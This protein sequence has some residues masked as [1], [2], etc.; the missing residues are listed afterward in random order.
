[1]IATE[2]LELLPLTGRQMRLWAGDLP[3]LERELGCAYAGE[4][5]EGFFLDIVRAQAE[6]TVL[7]EENWLYHT[8]WMLL[9]RQDRIVVGSADFKKPPNQ[10]GEVEIGYGL[11][12]RFWHNGYMAEAV[13]G[14]SRWALAQ[15]GITA[16]VAETEPDNIPSQNVLKRC[17]FCRCG[18][19][20]S[21]WWR[22]TGQG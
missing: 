13:R 12:E 19:E 14:M 21:R 6:K 8:F 22:L 17:G 9:R 16:V 15:P 2:R 10:R 5:L 11:G 4:P 20:Q 7:D 3:A 1:M 18:Q